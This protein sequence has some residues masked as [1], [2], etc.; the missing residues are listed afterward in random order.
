MSTIIRQDGF[1]I[2]IYSHDHAPAH[3]HAIKAGATVVVT[4]APLAIRENH[5]MSRV[6]RNQALSI[7]AVNQ[8]LLAAE[9]NR[10]HP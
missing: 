10:T 2:M 4:L 7:I 9:W 8:P 3:V 5:G 1:R 6:D